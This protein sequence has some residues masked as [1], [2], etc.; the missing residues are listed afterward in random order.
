[1]IPAVACPGKHHRFPG[2]IIRHGVWRS[3]RFCLSHRDIA[4]RLCVRGGL[5]SDGAIRQWC[6]TCGQQDATQRRRRRSRPGD[7]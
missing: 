5:V 6:R 3:A 1:M 2:E 4:E 7:T